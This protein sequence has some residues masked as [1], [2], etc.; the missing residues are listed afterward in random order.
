MEE[1]V[2]SG[3]YLL[4][5]LRR[6]VKKAGVDVFELCLHEKHSSIEIEFRW[7]GED[8]TENTLQRCIDLRDP[9][10]RSD[11][12]KWV[13]VDIMDYVEDDNRTDDPFEIE[14][15]SFH[16]DRSEKLLYTLPEGYEAPVLKAHQPRD[17]VDSS[18][19]IPVTIGDM[20]DK[21]RGADPDEIYA[22]RFI[23]KIF[24][25]KEVSILRA[26]GYQVGEKSPFIDAR[27]RQAFLDDFIDV[28]M[29]SN[30]PES[31]RKEWGESD[32]EDRVQKMI[33]HIRAMASIFSRRRDSRSYEKAI[34]EWREDIVYLTQYV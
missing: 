15:V 23:P 30:L 26:L 16:Y 34:K 9:Y 4:W 29:P 25:D 28:P 18:V 22:G 12:L 11:W 8:K 33:N 24:F 1:L 6:A 27:E 10:D 7:L 3:R 5:Q 31:Y 20:A 14:D 17:E 32:S 2:R 13:L 21:I 19:D